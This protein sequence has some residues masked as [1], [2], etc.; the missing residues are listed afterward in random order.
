L[1]GTAVVAGALALS[2]GANA[3]VVTVTQGGANADVTVTV[4]DATVDV[5]LQELQE[6]FGFE[7]EGLGNASKSEALTATMSGSVVSVVERLLRNWNH[8][9]IRAPDK[10]GGIEKILIIDTTYGTAAS[11]SK[12]AK[13]ALEQLENTK[14]ATTGD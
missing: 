2:S 10:P 11:Q 5:V 3:G 13:A 1:A 12:D 14:R 9:V 7:V 8:M 6:K 4:Q